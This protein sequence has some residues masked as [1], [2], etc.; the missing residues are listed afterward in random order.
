M[1]VAVVAAH[2]DDGSGRAEVRT[3]PTTATIPPA[4]IRGRTTLA[5]TAP[6]PVVGPAA[7]WR[8]TRS[9]E[10]RCDPP[11]PPDWVEYSP[12]RVE[13]VDPATGTVA[14]GTDLPGTCRYGRDNRSPSPELVVGPGAVWVRDPATC[15][16]FEIDAGTGAVVATSEV[17][18]SLVTADAGGPWVATGS[19]PNGSSAS[20]ARGATPRE[21][22]RLDPAGN[23]RDTFHIGDREVIGEV[24]L[25]DGVAWVTSVRYGQYVPRLARVDTATGAVRTTGISPVDVATGDGQV[26]FLGTGS[27]SR[28]PDRATDPGVLGEIDPR[29]GKV[30]RVFRLDLGPSSSP[31]EIVAVSEDTVSIVTIGRPREIVQVAT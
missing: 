31:D 7:S 2:R 17:V 16:M 14:F 28:R 21:L 4:T 27:R 9:Q 1:T 11:T 12:Y 5:E 23:V 13:K 25:L 22:V 30:E 26:W 3:S 18:G 10:R 8:V 20:C 15:T 19:G 6:E 29:T 24:A